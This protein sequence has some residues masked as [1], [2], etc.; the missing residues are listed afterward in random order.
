MDDSDQGKKKHPADLVIT[1]EARGSPFTS[2]I[3]V[4]KPQSQPLAEFKGKRKHM[5]MAVLGQGAE[6]GG[7][8]ASGSSLQKLK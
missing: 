8:C 2:Q 4:G 3:Q 6:E 7:K 5:L 1:L